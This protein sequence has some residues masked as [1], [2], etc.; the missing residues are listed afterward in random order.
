[1]AYSVTR[2]TLVGGGAL[3][4]CACLIDRSRGQVVPRGTI[5]NRSRIVACGI[6]PGPTAGGFVVDENRLRAKSRVS[7][8][9]DDHIGIEQ[10]ALN[11]SFALTGY[12]PKFS[13]YEDQEQ[14]IGARALRGDGDRT[15]ILFG[16]SLIREEVAQYPGLS[17]ASAIVGTLAHEWA[18]AFQYG[19]GMDEKRF[20][21]E[22]HADYL[23][24]WYLGMKT[25]ALGV[26]FI[27]VGV[28]ADSLRRKGS[29]FFDVNDYGLP[30]QRANAM[31][32]GYKFAFDQVKKLG[33]TYV[34]SASD[35]GYEYVAKMQAAMGKR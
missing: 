26:P 34:F 25:A 17:W 5:P 12:L 20:L 11:N 29:R 10:E 35:N 3:L 28:Y 23:S 1:M 27:D 4:F 31:E 19:H 13:F 21:W 6:A 7:D 32:A 33:T 16:L 30:Q 15:Q 2:R 9:L 8:Y 14:P 22:T 18:H 24:G